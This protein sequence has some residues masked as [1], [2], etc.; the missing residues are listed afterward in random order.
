M[1]YETP[2]YYAS[3]VLHHERGVDW[4]EKH[5]EGY[6]PWIKEVK[7]VMRKFVLSCGQ[8]LEGNVDGAVQEAHT[9][10]G[11]VPEAVVKRRKE[12]RLLCLLDSDKEGT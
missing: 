2:Y 11:K 4:F 8:S 1:L 5:W 9:T 3:I 12:Q 7:T 6:A 10:V